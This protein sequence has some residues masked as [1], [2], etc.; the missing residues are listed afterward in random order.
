MLNPALAKD[1]WLYVL[2]MGALFGFVA[3]ATY[4]LT[5]LAT[6]KDF[7]LK[8][9]L[10]DLLWGTLLTATVATGAFFIVRTLT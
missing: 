2:G 8:I 1:S 6:M 10:I 4:D 7:P 5:N 9:V 3:Y